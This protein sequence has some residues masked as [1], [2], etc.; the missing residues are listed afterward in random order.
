M[1]EDVDAKGVQKVPRDAEDRLVLYAIWARSEICELPAAS[2]WG[3][4]H[5][6]YPQEP[7]FLLLHVYEDVL[8]PGDAGFAPSAFLEKVQ[9]VLDAA[10]GHLHPEVRDLLALAEDELHQLAERD[11]AR[12]D[13]IRARVGSRTG[14]AGAAKKRLTR[15]SSDV[16]REFHERTTGGKRI[17]GD[18]SGTGGDWKAAVDAAKGPKAPYSATAKV[19]VGSLVEHP[20]FGVGVVTAIEPGR[21]HI[22]FESGARKLVVG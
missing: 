5:E 8:S 19:T 13:L 16:V 14:D 1:F 7:R 9:R 4:L 17:G 15:L 3:I 2:A 12:L 18:A 20:K 10:G 21:A 11:A 22:L 6:R